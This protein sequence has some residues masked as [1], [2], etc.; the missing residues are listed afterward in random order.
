MPLQEFKRRQHLFG[1]AEI[2]TMYDVPEFIDKAHQIYGFNHFINDAGGS[3]CEIDDEKM[4]EILAAHTLFIYIQA[5]EADEKR[6]I[7][8]S[9]SA[10]KPLYYRPEFLDEQLAIYMQENNLEYVAMI[11]PDDF[12]RWIF[13]RLFYSRIPRYEAI[14]KKYGYTIKTQ[15]LYQI[16]TEA[17]FLQLVETAITAKQA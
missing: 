7:A 12:V 3:L 9:K 4:F 6:L 1:K 2:A 10:P 17:D 15:D 11:D 16:K 14:A 13:P 8:R 5:N